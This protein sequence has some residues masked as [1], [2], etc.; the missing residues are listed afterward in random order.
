MT[1]VLFNGLMMFSY[2]FP[3]IKRNSFNLL[4]ISIGYMGEKGIWSVCV[5]DVY[6]CKIELSTE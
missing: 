5:C 6:M 2:S 1:A 3:H 4:K